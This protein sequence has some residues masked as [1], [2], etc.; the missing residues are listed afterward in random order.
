MLT[1]GIKANILVA[2][3]GIPEYDSVWGQALLFA[4]DRVNQQIFEDG[5]TPHHALTGK[6]SELTTRDH[7][8]GAEGV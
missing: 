4:A 3:A 7:V 2:T 1:E 5:R 8:F 6:K